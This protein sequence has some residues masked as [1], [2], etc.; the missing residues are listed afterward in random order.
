M[1][2]AENKKNLVPLLTAD[3]WYQAGVDIPSELIKKR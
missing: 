3:E 1:D 2:N